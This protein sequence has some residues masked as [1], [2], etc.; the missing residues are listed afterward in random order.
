[1][2]WCLPEGLRASEFEDLRV[3]EAM[4]PLADRMFWWEKHI[5]RAGHLGHTIEL[6]VVVVF[7]RLQTESFFCVVPDFETYS[8]LPICAKHGIYVREASRWATCQ[9]V[10]HGLLP[11]RAFKCALAREQLPKTTALQSSLVGSRKFQSV[12]HIP[13][14]LSLL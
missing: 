3:G 7:R 2:G 6:C 14:C 12:V 13:I 4:A 5:V 11:W 8:C 1:M 10:L 9:A